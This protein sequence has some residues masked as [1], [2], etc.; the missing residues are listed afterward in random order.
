MSPDV[1]A[2]TVLLVGVMLLRISVTDVFQR[3]VKVSMGPWLLASGVLLTLLGLAMVVRALRRPASPGHHADDVHADDGHHHLGGDRVGWLLLAPV[4]TLLLVAPPALGS[5][6]V[7]RTAAVRVSSGGA[8]F[9][10]L[11][12]AGAPHEMTLLEADQRAWDQAGRSF[13]AVPVRLTG[14]VASGDGE[15]APDGFR[16]AR[17]QIACC[18]ADAVAS[19]VHVRGIS[20]AP[21]ARDSWATVIGTFAGVAPDGL[22]IVRATS[23]QTVPAP[24]DTYE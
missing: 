7:D 15:G 10:P 17:Y 1:S 2:S 3:Y 6:G 16:I 14:F 8:V 22:P 5:F 24:L 4:L 13:G 12:P 11:D 23:V 9:A 20:G 18:A 21:P 19:V